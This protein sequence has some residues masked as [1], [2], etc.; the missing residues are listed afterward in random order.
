[1]P[2]S[3]IS[4]HATRGGGRAE[5]ND[6]RWLVPE[7]PRV[8]VW[9]GPLP[10]PS[11]RLVGGRQAPAASARPPAPPSIRPVAVGLHRCPAVVNACVRV[12]QPDDRGAGGGGG[13]G[14]AVM[15][16][17]AKKRRPPPPPRRGRLHY[18]VRN[19]RHHQ[20]PVYH[21]YIHGLITVTSEYSTTQ[22]I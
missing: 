8:Y 6:G 10:T 4:A 5:R 20:W 7:R 12:H 16:N 18:T 19:M 9:V 11:A 14:G 17:W 15:K 3:R 13:G 21:I 1:M 22:L 2:R